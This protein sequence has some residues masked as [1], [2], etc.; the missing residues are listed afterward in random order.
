MT[1]SPPP[2][3]LRR[4]VIA[5]TVGLVLLSVELVLRNFDATISGV[6]VAVSIFLIVA[7]GAVTMRTALTSPAR[8]SARGVILIAWGACGAVS[9]FFTILMIL[10]IIL[11]MATA[12]LAIWALATWPHNA[13]PAPPTDPTWTP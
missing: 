2:R 5:A 3:W 11:M 10:P 8:S 9:P 7:G 1:T 4:G 6:L 12:P 13:P